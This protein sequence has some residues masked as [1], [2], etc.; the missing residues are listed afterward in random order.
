MFNHLDVGGYL[1]WRLYPQQKTF[2]DGR[3]F[4]EDVFIEFD[5]VLGASGRSL[6]GLPEWRS[7]LN[8][9]G[10]ELVV[11]YSIN[12]HQGKV[13]PLISALLED[14][15]WQL[16]YLDRN[17]LIFIRDIPVNRELIGRFRKPKNMVYDQIIL[18]AMDKVSVSQN[19]ALYITIA[20]AFSMKKMFQE[21]A[22]A[23]RQAI[24]LDPHNNVAIARLRALGE[25]Q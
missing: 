21:A 14:D 15:E 8:R 1:I 23:Y 25:T 18:E 11:T 24:T 19:P 5:K 10:I 22:I 12:R 16:I 2:I 4:S 13:F 3:T 7:V 17:S 6:S 9:Y 20:E